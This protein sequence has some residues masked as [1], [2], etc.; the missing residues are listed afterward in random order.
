MLRLKKKENLSAGMPTPPIAGQPITWAVNAISL[1]CLEL[2]EY[3]VTAMA[4]DMPSPKP[5]TSD[6]PCHY[7]VYRVFFK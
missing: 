4:D 3:Y 2:Q 1:I 7:Q 5:F 6:I